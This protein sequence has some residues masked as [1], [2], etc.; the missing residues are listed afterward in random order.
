MC[1][2]TEFSRSALK[3]V[4]IKTGEPPNWEALELRCL[5]MGG[6]ADPKI[7][8]P[9]PRVTTSNLVV[10]R[11]RVYTYIEGTPKLGSAGP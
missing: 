9:S 2:H 10:L 7:H 5:A 6:V 4:G 1:Y 3:G 11:R 8:A